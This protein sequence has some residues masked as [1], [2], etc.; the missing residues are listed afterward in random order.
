MLTV[1]KSTLAVTT[2]PENSRADG[3][4][5]AWPHWSPAAVLAGRPRVRVNQVGYLRS[6]P[7]RAVLVTDAADPVRFE[8]VDGAGQRVL[9]G[10]TVP[11]S[12]RPE[13]TS[14]LTVHVVDF[15]ILD[16]A[17]DGYRVVA[18]G[19][20][21]HCFSI[22]G[23]YGD[24][25]A[26]A[27]Q[28]F[29][30]QRSG[31]AITEPAGYARPAGHVSVPP[32]SGDTRVAAWTGA[33]AA[34]LYP[35]WRCAG[36]FDVA[37]GWYDAGDF[38]KY[39]VSTALPVAQ[40]LGARERLLTQHSAEP[41]LADELLEECRWG[42][43]WLLTMQVPAGYPLAG[44]VFHRV[45]GTSWPA[46]PMWP[47][48]DPT[49]RVLHRPSTAATLALAGAAAFGSRAFAGIDAGYAETLLDAALVAYR[50][51][52]AQP[53]LLAPADS[54]EFGGGDYAD[55]QLDDD[56]YW[57]AT[58][59]FLATGRPEFRAAIDRSPCHHEEAAELDGFDWNRLTVPAWIDLATSGGADAAAVRTAARGLLIT[60]ADRLIAVQR[61]QPWGQP[62][63]PISGWDWGSN[64]LILNNLIVLATAYDLTLD[65]RYRSAALTGIDYLFG[66]NAL[67]Q[68]YVTGYGTD[69]SRHQRTRQYAHDLDPRFPPVPTGAIA[70]GANSRTYPGFPSDA[71]LAGLPP[72][73]C[74]LDEPTSEVTNDVCIRWNAPLVW[75]ATFLSGLDP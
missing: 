72:Q 67:G 48:L 59:L 69:D 57:A 73:Q 41:A 26:D 62:Y 38:G 18:D 53:V 55:D 49:R 16:A 34:A 21:S 47:H 30:L 10:I 63:A 12:V 2:S 4:A 13:P 50:A 60:H 56:F 17:G 66:R 5:A 14:G 70:G 31:V 37:G 8:I 65:D 24:L 71:R 52:A 9:D 22:G 15:T 51:A 61:R 42:L 75:M 1:S 19:A 64:G 40:L 45:H 25:P 35:G 44:M 54:A 36:T 29:R 32:N 46:L 3:A 27:L 23:G 58:Q 33:G 6:G 7:K 20:T 11:W 68:S 74:Y 43:D 39:V 28:F